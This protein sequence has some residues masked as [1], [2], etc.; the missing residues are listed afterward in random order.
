MTQNQTDIRHA[1]VR[2]L[3]HHIDPE[4]FRAWPTL[5][6]GRV[7]QLFR[8]EI[9]VAPAASFNQRLAWSGHARWC[10]EVFIRTGRF[11]KRNAGRWYAMGSTE[12]IAKTPIEYASHDLAEVER[13]AAEAAQETGRPHLVVEVAASA[14][15]S[16]WVILYPVTQHGGGGQR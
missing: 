13:Q 15:K 4:R 16:A 12:T 6:A 10:R 8:G 11:P 14:D 3:A 2:Q 9:S 7:H 5:I 1:A